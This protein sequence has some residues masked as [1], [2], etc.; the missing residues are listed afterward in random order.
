MVDVNPGPGSALF[1]VCIVG[2]AGG[3]HVRTRA[4][5]MARLGHEIHLITPRASGLGVLNES[6][7][8][9]GRF[10][11]I[12]FLR[13]FNQGAQMSD[14]ARQLRAAPGDIVHIHYAS[15]LGAWL[16]AASQDRRHNVRAR[17]LKLW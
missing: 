13:L 16:F 12:P 6:V 9:A 17:A 11:D 14:H 10:A 1:P 5:A 7:P 2:D 3:V 4:L 8:V 15:S